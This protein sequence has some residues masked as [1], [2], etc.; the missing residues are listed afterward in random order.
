METS[1]ITP[2]LGG[3]GIS[4]S[5]QA[6]CIYDETGKLRLVIG[7][8]NFKKGESINLNPDFKSAQ[9]SKPNDTQERIF[10]TNYSDFEIYKNKNGIKVQ[11]RD[12]VDD[13]PNWA[14]EEIS[15][16][17]IPDLISALQNYLLRV[18]NEAD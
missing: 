6:I 1:N 18:R 17:K 11:I 12:D 7:E 2:S 5:K 13:Y 9:S 10:E 14:I 3:S 16:E 8:L 15:N 4:K